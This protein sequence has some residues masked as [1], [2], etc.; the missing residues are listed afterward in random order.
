MRMRIVMLQMT[1]LTRGAQLL[2]KHLGSNTQSQVADALTAVI[3]RKV[4][5]ASVSSWSAGRH[6]PGGQMMV[7]LLSVAQIPVES[8]LESAIPSSGE[9]PVGVPP[10][11]TG[12]ENR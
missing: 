6:L 3:G 9:H 1:R 4:H 11:P 10:D 2:Q 12:T 5:Q 7:A 8:W